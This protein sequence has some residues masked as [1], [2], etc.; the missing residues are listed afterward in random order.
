MTCV[1]W[2][3]LSD[4]SI[5]RRSINKSN[6]FLLLASLPFTGITCSTLNR[7]TNWSVRNHVLIDRTERT[8][9][10]SFQF[11]E[12]SNFI[13]F[14]FSLV[15]LLL[16]FM[17]PITSRPHASCNSTDATNA[18]QNRMFICTRLSFVLSIRWIWC[19][20]DRF[21]EVMK[22]FLILIIIGK[23]NNFSFCK[24]PTTLIPN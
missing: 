20:R 21:S 4:S 2:C 5:R 3:F 18:F 15:P 24:T 23:I 19:L 1:S 7:P 11:P 8:Q 22:M 14:I 13:Y 6:Q 16:F 12:T 10:P 17:L 9:K